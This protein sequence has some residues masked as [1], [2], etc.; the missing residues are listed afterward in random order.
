RLSADGLELHVESPSS[1]T[2]DWRIHDLRELLPPAQAEQLDTLSLR[3]VSEPFSL[4]HG[5]LFRAR[6]VKLS[7]Q[8]HVLVL[9]GHHV[10]LDGWSIAVLVRDVGAL[11]SA[12]LEGRADAGLPLAPT[13]SEYSRVTREAHESDAFAEAIGYW[14]DRFASGAPILDL[15]TDAPRP[16][17]R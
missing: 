4:E 3:E 9:T 12:A 1:F 15:P 16:P 2:L 6:L 10:V 5:P 8:R 17:I 13:F 11:Y 14:T 7:L